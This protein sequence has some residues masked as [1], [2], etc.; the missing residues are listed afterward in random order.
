MSVCLVMEYYIKIF[1]GLYLIVGLI[2]A[3]YVVM[4]QGGGLFSIPLNT[5]LGPIWIPILAVMNYIKVNKWA[6]QGRKRREE[7]VMKAKASET[8]K[9]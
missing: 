3:I 8:P 9:T 4:V 1:V 5:L 2:Y 7:R 6:A